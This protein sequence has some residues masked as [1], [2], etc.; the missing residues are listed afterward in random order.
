[1][2]EQLKNYYNQY[3]H[4][5]WLL[6]IAV[7]VLAFILMKLHSDSSNQEIESTAQNVSNSHLDN[8]KQNFFKKE[9][10]KQRGRHR[11]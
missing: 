2:L 7:I 9:R 1:M 3:K 10:I 6:V 11:N 5:S 8:D 4:F